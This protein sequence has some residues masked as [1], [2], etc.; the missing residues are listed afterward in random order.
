MY[1]S[2]FLRTI[3]RS[4]LLWFP[5]IEWSIFFRRFN[6]F[7]YAVRGAHDRRTEN[8]TTPRKKTHGKEWRNGI[9]VILVRM[10]NRTRRFN[11]ILVYPLSDVLRPGV[12]LRKQ[13]CDGLW[14]YYRGHA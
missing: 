9:S 2:L 7:T 3:S 10:E 13:G 4:Y 11:S 12:V 5:M 8:E 14:S 6:I 1:I